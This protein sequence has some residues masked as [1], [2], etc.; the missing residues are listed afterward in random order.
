ML[1]CNV[2]LCL[3]SLAWWGL[4]SDDVGDEDE[5]DEEEEGFRHGA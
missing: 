4:G 5:E 3:G 2:N 1:P